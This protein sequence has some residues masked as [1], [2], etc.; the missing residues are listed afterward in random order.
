MATEPG[1]PCLSLPVVPVGGGRSC[2]ACCVRVGAGRDRLQRDLLRN[3]RRFA[4]T[5][6]NG[7]RPGRLKTLRYHLSDGGWAAYLLA[8]V[9]APL[10]FGLSL[11]AWW[12]WVYTVCPFAGF[13]DERNETPGCLIHPL[14]QRA[15]PDRRRT[16]PW[17]LIPWLQCDSGYRCAAFTASQTAWNNGFDWYDVTARRE[18]ALRIS[19]C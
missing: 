16:E 15:G 8:G 6:M 9:L 1:N 17:Y 18:S 14:R 12:R 13:L 19:D 10:T 7:H 11:L 4:R 2:V 5:R 3:T